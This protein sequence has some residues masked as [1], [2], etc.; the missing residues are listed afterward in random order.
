MTLHLVL[1]IVPLVGPY[2]VQKGLVKSADS[3]FTQAAVAL[4]QQGLEVVTDSE[5][6]MQRFTTYPLAGLMSSGVHPPAL[7]LSR[8][9]ARNIDSVL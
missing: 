8:I 4:M 5:Q 6:A 7:H 1:Q 2:L 9:D 3:E